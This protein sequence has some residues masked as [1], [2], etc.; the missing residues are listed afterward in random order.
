MGKSQDFKK[1]IILCIS[2][3]YVMQK[4]KVC[5]EIVTFVLLFLKNAGQR[6]GKCNI[7]KAQAAFCRILST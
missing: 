5:G 7:R 6:R 1:S 4:Q 2:I 3:S